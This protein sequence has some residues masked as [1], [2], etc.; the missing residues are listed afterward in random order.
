MQYCEL[1]IENEDVT[2]FILVLIYVF[3]NYLFIVKYF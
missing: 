1:N 2:F 3:L